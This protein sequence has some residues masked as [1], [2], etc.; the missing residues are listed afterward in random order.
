MCCEW[1][2]LHNAADTLEKHKSSTPEPA[3]QLS[4]PTTKRPMLN[5]VARVTGE[6][7]NDA[8]TSSRQTHSA[9]RSRTDLNRFGLDKIKRA[10]LM[11]THRCT[12]Y[13]RLAQFHTY[14]KYSLCM[15]LPIFAANG[16]NYWPRAATYVNILHK[17]G[18][19][20]NN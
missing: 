7:K 18:H 13:V 6:F 17:K 9:T 3:A 14:I 16:W 12:R 19:T 20:D 4:A 10:A 1:H 15:C 2:P 11:I 5:C 8:Q